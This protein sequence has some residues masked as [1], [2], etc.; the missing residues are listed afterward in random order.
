MKEGFRILV[1]AAAWAA[2]LSPA[3]VRAGDPGA[4]MAAA[5]SN[6]VAGVMKG[7]QDV[8]DQRPAVATFRGQMKPFMEHTPGVFGA[9]LI[10]T[11]FVI[12][13]VYY[14]RD[15]LA[16]GYDL[17]KVRELDYFWKRMQEKPAP[18]L[19]EPGH[20]SLVQPR[21]VALRCP[22]I[23]DGQFKGIVSAMIHTD[24]F[25]KAVGLDKCSAFQILCL[26]KLAEEKG[27]LAANPHE[28]KL[29][30]PSTEWVIRF[31]E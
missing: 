19:S 7:L 28:I 14:R 21:L 3:P 26:G 13:Q 4:A 20:G 25:L 24:T 11:N 2:A 15:F 5:V 10:D 9:S 17:K 12:R 30:L 6:Y 1:C 23:V 8:A 18:Q 16:V 27:T 31:Q 22:I 29:R